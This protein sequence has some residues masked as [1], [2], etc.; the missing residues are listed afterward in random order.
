MFDAGTSLTFDNAATLLAAGA[1]AIDAGETQ[2]D[3]A[4]LATL[5]SSAV[6]TLLAW[7]R[8][9]HSLG[10][11][12]SFANVPANLASLISLYDT[13]ALLTASSLASTSA[14]PSAARNDLPHH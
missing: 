14:I 2:F 10:R 3:F 7:Q 12:L 13:I 8:K 11:T 4:A 1:R 5:D 9:A 6:A